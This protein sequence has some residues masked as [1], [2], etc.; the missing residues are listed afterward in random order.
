MK[1]LLQELEENAKWRR[2]HAHEIN[3]EEALKQGLELVEKQL[4][5][6]QHKDAKARIATAVSLGWSEFYFWVYEGD[7]QPHQLFGL[8]SASGWQEQVPFFEYQ[9]ELNFDAS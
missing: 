9:K 8:N 5:P 4:K 2:E 3:R 7:A 6:E 1:N